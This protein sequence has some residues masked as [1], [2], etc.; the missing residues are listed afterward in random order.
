M[1]AWRTR[2]VQTSLAKN[3]LQI[4]KP[5]HHGTLGWVEGIALE[6][7]ERRVPGDRGAALKQLS[8]PGRKGCK[9]RHDFRIWDFNMSWGEGLV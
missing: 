9:G 2:V 8:R 5:T 7:G 6:L 4:K 1:M 3:F